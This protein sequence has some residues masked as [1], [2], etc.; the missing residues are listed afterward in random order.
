[1]P[2][3]LPPVELLIT[4]DQTNF[5]VLT[6]ERVNVDKSLHQIHCCTQF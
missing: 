5:D 4:F 3:T 6:N 1:M 2:Y